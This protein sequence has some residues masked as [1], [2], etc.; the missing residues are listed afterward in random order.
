MGKILCP[1]FFNFCLQCNGKR[2]DW[3]H[4][5]DIY[6]QETFSEVSMRLVPKLTFEHIKLTLYSKIIVDLA[7]Q[8]KYAYFYNFA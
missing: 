6:E 2:I 8:F 4:L 1:S 3:Q 5:V 7:A